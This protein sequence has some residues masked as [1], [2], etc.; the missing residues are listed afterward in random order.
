MAKV[1]R[2]HWQTDIGSG[3]PRKDRRSC[4][5][6]AYI[7]DPLVGR[8]LT[9]DAEVAA[10]V[11]DAERSIVGL[12]T[13]ASALVD[14][15]ALARLLLRA[16]SVASSKIEGLEIGGRRLMRAAAARELGEESTDVTAAEV[17]GNIAGMSWAVQSIG[18]AGTITLHHLLAVHRHLLSGTRLDAR[19]GEI[20]TDQNWIGGSDYNPCSASFVPPPPEFVTELLDDLIAFCNNDDLPAVAQAALAHAQFET[21]HPF[22]D[23]NG[24]TGRALIH[25]VL[26]RRGLATRVIVPVS[27]ILATWSRSYVD[28]LTATRYRGPAT[29]P[30]AHAGCNRWIALFASAC[31]RGVADAAAFEARVE[32]V[33]C[34]WRGQLGA[35]RANSSVD[36]LLRALPGAP[37]LTVNGAADVLGRSFE[38]TNNAIQRLVDA[39]ILQQVR[40]GR[41]N[42]AFEAPDVITVFTELERQL[43]SPEGDTLV[44]PPTRVVPRLVR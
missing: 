18:E 9:L 43:A 8:P 24:R 14:T 33:E 42:R 23:G 2:R 21:I 12:D 41:R 10:D 30:A 28:G 16:E 22:I 20:R 3:L 38:A 19:A 39:G 31:R 36:L 4:A 35:V 37:I 1:V 44:S 34:R 13:T 26:R 6:D 29:S 40:A 15:E 5:Y 17:L 11:T 32:E 25:L 7:P 27:L